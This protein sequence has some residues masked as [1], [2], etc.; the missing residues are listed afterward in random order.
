[1]T[2]LNTLECAL[3]DLLN[4]GYADLDELDILYST[5]GDEVLDYDRERIL[6]ES[7]GS[8]SGLNQLTR[9]VYREI[10]QAVLNKI[11]NYYNE[12]VNTL[13]EK[14]NATEE[15]KETGLVEELYTFFYYENNKNEYE[16]AGSEEFAPL[17]FAQRKAIEYVIEKMT[18]S[19]PY[20]NG[21]DNHFQNVLDQTL[22]KEYGIEDNAIMAIQYAI[23]KYT[24]DFED[25]ESEDDNV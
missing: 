22:K 24:E 19:E 10:T 11:E 12:Y 4:C 7:V 25:E 23:D 16:N 21:S 3:T 6:Q 5:L 9:T 17:T 15:T 13:D 8:G 20:A 14:G 1:M 2:Q 18:Y